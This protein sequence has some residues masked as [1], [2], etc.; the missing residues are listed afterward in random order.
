MSMQSPGWM[1][2]LLIAAS[3]FVSCDGAAFRVETFT[4][5]IRA[6]PTPADAPRP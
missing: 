3:V 2:T 1:L 6:H 4:P 5:V